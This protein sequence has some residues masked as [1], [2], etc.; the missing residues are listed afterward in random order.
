MDCAENLRCPED[1]IL[2]WVV[3]NGSKTAERFA[4]EN[5]LSG[6]IFVYGSLLST[7][8]VLLNSV[9][10]LVFVVTSQGKR[11]FSIGSQ[12]SSCLR[13]NFS[14]TQLLIGAVVIPGT[15]VIDHN[16]VWPFGPGLCRLWLVLKVAFVAVT[17][18]SLAGMTLNCVLDRVLFIRQLW[19]GQGKTSTG[20]A[21]A[22]VWIL[23]GFSALPLLLS[24]AGDDDVILEDV[25]A[26]MTSKADAVVVLITSFLFPV[27][28]VI[29]GSAVIVC[30]GLTSGD[31][32][33][34]EVDLDDSS[35]W[36]SDGTPEPETFVGHV[37]TQ[38]S[39]TV[40]LAI[41]LCSVVMW[42]PLLAVNALVPFCDGAL[43]VDPGLW[44]LFLW[45]GYANSGVAP[46]LWFADPVVRNGVRSIVRLS[47]TRCRRRD[48]EIEVE[49][50]KG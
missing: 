48:Q 19:T 6:K 42:S 14:L 17:F 35:S 38:P 26:S 1:N 5:W 3:T 20:L 47:F 36:I 22:A 11:D 27:C 31:E 45:I 30:S 4:V 12:M 18:W 41:D 7:W 34:L 25:C 49:Q 2:T 10:C 16:G 23:S 28:F 21:L 9:L 33:R 15:L 13:V 37:D 50:M 46:C 32:R 29:A 24:F 43:C 39:S 44:T 40:L 8:V